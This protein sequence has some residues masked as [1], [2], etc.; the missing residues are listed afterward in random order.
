MATCIN[1]TAVFNQTLRSLA[2]G[3]TL[4]VPHGKTFWF[5]G[6]IWAKKLSNITIQIDGDIKYIDDEKAW[7]RDSNGKVKECMY[8]EEIDGIT[9]TSSNGPDAMGLIDG[10]G[11]RWWGAIQYLRKGENRPR[12]L[13]V[14]NSRNIVIEYIYFKNSPYWNVLL[15][16]LVKYYQRVNVEQSKFVFYIVF[17]IITDQSTSLGSRTP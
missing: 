6:G 9:F 16:E 17:I 1:N 15:D 8:F 2:P 11:K 13:H 3:D 14:R 10:N 7:P 4:L 5:I 12:L